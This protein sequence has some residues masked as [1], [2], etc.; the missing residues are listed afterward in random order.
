MTAGTGISITKNSSNNFTIS[1]TLLDV[2]VSFNA[3]TG[4]GLT[5]TA[6]DP[7]SSGPGQAG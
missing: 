1:N 6:V 2:T 4:Q 3:V 5:Y 7:I